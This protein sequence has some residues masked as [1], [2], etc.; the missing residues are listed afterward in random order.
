VSDPRTTP[1]Q[2]ITDRRDPAQVAASV[3]DLCSAPDGRR[4]RQ[5]IC[6]DAVTI[7]HRGAGWCYVQSGKDGYCGHVHA[8]ALG[9]DAKPTH[10]VISPA[11]HAYAQADIK[12]AVRIAL[13]FS[14]RVTMSD[15]AGRFAATNV[16]F[17]PLGHLSPLSEFEVDPAA[18]AEKFL[19][20]PYLWGGNSRWGIDCS[21]LVQAALLACGTACPGDSDQQQALGRPAAGPYQ[22]NDLLFWKGHVAL[23]SDPDTMLHSNAY[24]MSTNYEDIATAI[25][26]I[27]D[28]GD[29][30][31]VAHRRL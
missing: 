14:S 8:D 11:T 7:L 15:V 26:R 9:P 3:A 4:L 24:S 16:G 27:E 19:G 22:R 2:T 13:S 25:R 5:L 30:P 20:T 29:G 1:D 31:V 6:G 28:G 23:V 10:R 12:S 17:V 21:G 18:V